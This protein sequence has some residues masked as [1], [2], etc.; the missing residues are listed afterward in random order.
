MDKDPLELVGFAHAPSGSA[1]SVTTCAAYAAV[2][3]NTNQNHL[4]FTGGFCAGL[5]TSVLVCYECHAKCH[6]YYVLS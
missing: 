1:D 5:P 3:V 2:S 4:F 6:A